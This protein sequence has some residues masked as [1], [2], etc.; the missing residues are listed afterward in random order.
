MS[1]RE[2]ARPGSGRFVTNALQGIL[3]VAGGLLVGAGLAAIG[4][5]FG[6]FGPIVVVALVAIP[7][8]AV[9]TLLDPRWGVVAVFATFPIGSLGVPAGTFDLEIA[10]VAALGV[11]VVIIVGRLAGGRTPLPWPSQM[12]WILALIA[13][14]LVGLP[15]AVDQSL[16]IKQIA[17]LTLGT[18]FACVVVSAC[19]TVKDI[20]VI[21]V[22]LIAIAVMIGLAA[23][24]QGADFQSTFGGARVQG[25]AVGSFDHSNQLGSLSAMTALIT[26]G[27]IAGARS[28]R[29]RWAGIV[30]VLILLGGQALT[31][32]RGAWI[33]TMAGILFLLVVLP[34]ARRA[35]MLLAVPLFSVGVA[36]AIL[37]PDNTQVQVIQQRFE[38]LTVRSPYDDRS[39][40]WR[41]AQREALDDPLTGQGAGGFPAAST[42]SASGANTVFAYHAHNIFLTW[43]AEAG[44]P[45]VFAMLGFAFALGIS[46]S[47][48][49]RRADGDSDEEVA[50]HALLVGLMAALLALLVQGLVDYTLRNAVIFL[51]VMTVIGCLLAAI[52]IGPSVLAE[53]DENEPVFGR[54]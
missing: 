15:S 46:S 45:A 54:A 39:A 22:G 17:A 30:A 4:A 18:I 23:F 10:Q 50:Y 5:K 2:A 25:R 1:V 40:I 44:F 43:G 8:L 3:L 29:A 27:L 9:A 19:R 34:H 37:A 47:R 36:I 26:V 31:L 49:R 35:L 53:D 13:W 38:S 11:A 32:S 51:A 16:A 42:R 52:R 7:M 6:D 24:T 21:L 28:R 14:T 41:E 48:A 12:W 20:Q 33:G